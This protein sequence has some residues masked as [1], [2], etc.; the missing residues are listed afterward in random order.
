MHPFISGELA[1]G[2]LKTRA[3]VLSSLHALPT[4]TLASNTEVLQLI[5]E[6]RLWDED[7]V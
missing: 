7:W 3:A 6:R 5:E 1:C 4:A 2:S